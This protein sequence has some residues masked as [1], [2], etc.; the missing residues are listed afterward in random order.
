MNEQALFCDGT[1]AYVIPA[2]PKER[3]TVRLRF[4]T[5]KDDVDCVRLITGNVGYDME[6]ESS[7]GLFDYYT[8]SWKLGEEPFAAYRRNGKAFMIS[9]LFL[10]FLRRTGPKAR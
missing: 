1:A 3:E 4:R 6:K 8:I 9:G 7:R 10:V 5:A 2:E